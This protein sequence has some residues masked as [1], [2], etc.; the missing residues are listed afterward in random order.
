MKT[1][2]K[3]QDREARSED[4]RFE[5]KQQA[6]FAKDIGAIE[7]RYGVSYDQSKPC[8]TLSSHP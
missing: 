2:A 1:D 3:G 6:G 8:D 7:T 4:Q 5:D